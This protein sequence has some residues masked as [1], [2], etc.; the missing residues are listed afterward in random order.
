MHATR[1]ISRLR[2]WRASPAVVRRWTGAALLANIAIVGTGGLVRLT[3]SGLGC[4]S[5]PDCTRSSLVPTAELS[6]H[7]Y[8]EFGNRLFT[9]VVLAT[10]VGALL[11]VHRATPPRADLKAWVWGT[12]LGVPAQAVMGG[13]T[14]LTDLNPWAVAAHFLLSMGVVALATVAWLRAKPDDVPPAPP[15]LR[16]AGSALLVLTFAVC[17]AG[18]TVTGAGPH[19]GDPRAARIPARPASLAQLH[20]DLAMLLI[21]LAVGLAI[22]ATIIDVGRRARLATRGLVGVLGFQAVIG[23]AQYFLGLP[24]GLVEIHMLGAALLVTGATC[25][26]VSLRTPAADRVSRTLDTDTPPVGD[27]SALFPT[28]EDKSA[29]FA[30]ARGLPVTPR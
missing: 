16:R 2:S 27:E 7:K 18:T 1:V 22:A 30:P 10:A 21:G 29:E 15:L 13:I 19:A 9:Y 28:G 5:W 12:L 23:W 14:V 25:V 26:A 8:V 24:V 17:A 4:P 6:W 3:G 20:A 11:A